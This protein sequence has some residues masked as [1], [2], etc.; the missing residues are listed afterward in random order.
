MNQNKATGIWKEVVSI[1][2][3]NRVLNLSI[4]GVITLFLGYFATGVGISHHLTR[5]LPEHDSTHV[6]YQNFRHVFGA[7]GTSV[8]LGV[9]DPGIFDLDG[10][11]AYYAL[12][13][14]IADM[15]GVT[16]VLSIAGFYSLRRNPEKRQLEFYPVVPHKPHSQAQVDSIKSKLKALPFYG[17]RLYNL[18]NQT[19]IMVIMLDPEMINDAA[20]I[21]LIE[22]ITGNARAYA[23]DRGVSVHF[24]GMPYIRTEITKKVQNELLLFVLLAMVIASAALFLFFRSFKAVFFPLIIVSVSVIWLLGFISLLGFQITILSGILPPLIIVIGVE[25]C[26]F[27]LN[28]YHQEF[29]KHHNN[30]KALS[31]MVQRVG[32]ATFLTNLTTAAGFAAF[33]ITGNSSLVEFGIVASAGIIFVFLLSLFLIPIFFSYTRPPRLRHVRHLDSRS[34]KSVLRQIVVL[35][36]KKRAYIYAVSLIFLL[37][38]ITG[39]N[40]LQTRSHIVDDLSTKDHI[41]QDIMFFEE[42]L[43]GVMPLDIIIDTRSPRGA[44]RSHNL[45]K[46]DRLQD[47]LKTMT[48]LS[49]PLSMVEFIKF[50]KQAFYAENPAYYSLPNN[51]ERGFIMSWLPQ[52]EQVAEAG[53]L[54]N[55]T[56]SS[57]QLIRVS[58][59]VANVNNKEMDHIHNKL[60][61]T[62]TAI[63][64]PEDYHITV[65]GGSVVSLKG[66]GYMIKNLKQSLLMAVIVI[67]ILLALLFNSLKMVIISMI[68]NLL[69]LLLT[70]SLMGFLN[71]P[72]KPSTVLIFSIALGISVDNTIHFLS[73]YRMELRANNWYI[74]PS[75]YQAL[76]ETGYS[77]IYSSCVLFFGFIIFVLSSFGGIE[78]MGYLISFTLIMAVLSNLILLPSLLLSLDRMVTTKSFRKPLL[79]IFNKPSE[80][81]SNENQ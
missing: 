78:A 50:G 37:A 56:D 77:M 26:I 28:K 43:G 81:D 12:T 70:A 5:M 41:Y 8:F 35:V 71:I 49:Q 74:K 14:Q 22:S 54:H 59:Q 1:I 80:L 62:L 76:I 7:D 48:S 66:S 47:S 10:Y 2:L 24:S 79:K 58:M 55:L 73:R 6:A 64:P 67:I 44:L 27:L 46:T 3:R 34:T 68:P 39:M 29:R 25:N 17:D 45:Q 38:G 36:R 21:Q 33:T 13:H 32:N 20:R 53:M 40:R 69:P 9:H 75:V 11:L 19:A 42:Q 51:R 18:S 16:E 61:S 15:E 4:I 23:K 63:F 60:N 57:M 30:I 65:T 52:M 72:I 31:R